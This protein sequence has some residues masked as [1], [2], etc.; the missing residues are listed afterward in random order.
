L[1]RE[2]VDREQMIDYATNKPMTDARF[3]RFLDEHAKTSF[4]GED[5]LPSATPKARRML[6]N[7]RDY[8][9]VLQFKDPESW[10]QF[11]ETVGE[12]NDVFET[13]T[14]HVHSMAQDIA[15]LENLGPNPQAWKRFVLDLYDREPR[16]LPSRRRRTRPERHGALLQAEPE[17]RG[18]R[19]AGAPRVR[20][21][22]RRGDRAEQD[23]GE[24]R[25]GQA[26]GDSRHGFPA[27]SSAA[28]CCHRSMIPARWRWRPGS[29]ACQR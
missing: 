18:P 4:R 7:S 10:M 5:G 21:P 20:E 23:P 16:G 25:N 22:V 9:R 2:T 29:T 13:V 6:A 3:E 15:M 26:V 14:S 28:R 12:N 1:I 11:A 17:D 8:A 27:S 19:R 24:H